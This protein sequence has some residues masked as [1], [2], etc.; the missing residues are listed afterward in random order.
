[1]KYTFFLYALFFS[2]TAF[3]LLAQ[4]TDW[5]EE[6]EIEEAEVVIEKDRE[7]E[8]PRANRKFERVP[9]LPVQPPSIELNYQ[10][11]DISPRLQ[12]LKPPI[13]VLKVKEPPLPKLYPNYLKAGFG[14]YITPYLEVYANSA[15][16]ED[17][18]YGVHFN[19]LSSRRGPVD[20]ANSG[21]SNTRL[22]LHGNYFAAGHTFFGEA[23]YQRE[24]YHFFGY[25][26]GLEIDRDSI[27]QIFNTVTLSGGL[28]RNDVDA[29][30]DYRLKL[31]YRHLDDA[32]NASENQFEVNFHASYD[33]SD[34]LS[35][36]LQTDIWSSTLQDSPLEAPEIANSISRNLFR[37][38]P[39]FRFRTS[40]EAQQGLDVRAGINL[41]YENDTLSNADRL[42][43]YPYATAR[44]YLANTISVYASLEGDIQRVSLLDLTDEN[45]WLMP[46][47]PV[48]HTNKSLS[49][50][51][52]ITG[53]VNSFLGFNAGLSA[54]NYKNMY[55]FVNSAEDSTKF[56]I[57]Y[58]QGNVFVFNFFG[59]LN[60]N[61]QDRFRTTLRADYFAYSMDELESPWHRPNLK[62]SIL[63]SYNVYDK[64]LL[65]AEFMLINGLEG[66]NMATAQSEEL[67]VIADLSM[68]ADYIFSPRF[69]TFLQFK[70]I[71]AQNYE[72][73]LNYPSRGI[74]VLAGITYSF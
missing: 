63:S 23:S 32:Y 15:R 25:A 52:G 67:P 49:F 62:M 56:D 64:L 11:V 50:G 3:P 72:R 38:K 7:I 70:N 46:N 22:G 68:K 26:P 14:N 31:N 66:L 74:M 65:N 54:S 47:V 5:E 33:I 19:H 12:P 61:S 40:E 42:H 24:R 44:Y 36:Q 10:F 16:S 30:L 8:L 37:F 35:F 57:L 1:M 34:L 71:F 18:S 69:S 9:P 48:Y 21:N 29:L 41:V 17:Y 60:I 55:F 28:E 27:R 73:Y 43:F 59:E 2:F 58:D 53:S 13:R 39:Y 20:G 6:G 4:Q 51:G 45:P